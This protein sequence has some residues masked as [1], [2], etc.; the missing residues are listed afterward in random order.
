MA[1]YAEGFNILAHA[2]VGRAPAAGRRRNVAAPRSRPL[3]ATTSRCRTSPNCGGVAASS[4]RGCS[5]SPRARCAEHPGP[6]SRSPATSSDSGEGRWTAH[7][8]IETSTP[9]PVLTAALF[10]R[11]SSRGEDDFASRLLSAHALPVRRPRRARRRTGEAD[12]RAARRR[13]RPLRRH[14]RPRL[15][16]DL[17]RAAGD[18]AAR[19]ARRPGHRRRA[20]GLDRRPAVRARAGRASRRT[21]ASTTTPTS[22]WPRGSRYV[23]GDYQEPATFERLRQALG[24]AQRPLFYLAIPPSLFAA[25]AV[26]PRAVGMRRG[27]PGS[28]SRSRSAA[29]S[30]RRARSTRRCTSRFP[31][32]AIYRIDHFL[33]KEPVQNLLYFRFANAFLEPIWNADYVAQRADHDGGGVRRSRT[34]QVLRGGRRASATSSRIICCRCW[35]C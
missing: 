26:E 33:G 10:Q 9:A 2:G 22:G 20:A 23:A 18:G 28:S 7:A 29:T 17:S 30:R 3:S 12:A 6:A 32:T 24:A 5:T 21:A 31:S 16:A 15:P 27:G 35:R 13:A 1:A 34:R 8:A 25:V 4:A 14:R 19:P 11:F